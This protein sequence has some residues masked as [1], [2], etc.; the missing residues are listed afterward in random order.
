GCLYPGAKFQ[1]YQKS[2][3]LSYDV[4]VE[5][6]NVDMPNSH[7]DG[8]LNIRGLTE[9]WP[10]MTTYFEAEIIG[11]EHRF[12][13][14]KWGASQADDVKHWS[15]FMPFELQ[16]TFKKEGPRFNHLNK[17]FVFMRWKE[18]FLVPDWRVRDI[19]GASFA[20]FYYVCVE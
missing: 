18:R 13:T 12:T 5:I 6:L 2:G 4:T 8:Y 11:Q 7:L 20:G 1:G 17:P 16:E 3:R 9:D 15:R 10:E 14:G 19:H